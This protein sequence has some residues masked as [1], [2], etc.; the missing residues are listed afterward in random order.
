MK[1]FLS[2][3][4]VA[5]INRACLGKGWLNLLSLK[6]SPVHLDTAEVSLV[7]QKEQLFQSLAAK[8]KH[9]LLSW[10]SQKVQ[11]WLTQEGGVFA[12]SVLCIGQ[13]LLRDKQFKS[14]F[15]KSLSKMVSRKVLLCISLGIPQ[16]T[17]RGIK[18][19]WENLLLHSCELVP[20]AAGSSDAS[21]V[22]QLISCN[23][24]FL[25]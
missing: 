16:G 23:N 3:P 14:L 25:N 4:H 15:T 11:D 20:L 7:T 17:L 13:N 8:R 12:A 22:I 18:S 6:Y 19:P 21:N 9:F 24:K 10:C 2:F 5:S 1:P